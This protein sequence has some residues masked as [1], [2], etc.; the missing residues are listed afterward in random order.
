[1]KSHDHFVAGGGRRYAGRPM[2]RLFAILAFIG[3]GSLIS[4]SVAL[5]C[6]GWPPE[7]FSG[8]FWLCILLIIQ[9]PVFIVLAVKFA[10]TEKP[11]ERPPHDNNLRKLY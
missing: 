7:L 4:A 6:A 11:N 8:Q 10:L 5:Y 9:E 1:M 3:L 2:T